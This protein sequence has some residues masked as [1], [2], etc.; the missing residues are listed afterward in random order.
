MSAAM[1]HA[2]PRAA[3]LG[4]A[5]GFEW[6]KLRTVRSTWWSVISA[7]L[8]LVAVGVIVGMSTAASGDNGYDVTRPAPHAA[9]EVYLIAQLPVVALAA[10]A[11]TSE[12]STG[13][14]RTTLQAVPV[15]GRML[16]A[17]AVVVAAATGGCGALLCLIGTVTIDLFAGGYTAYTASEL[18]TTTAASALYLGLLG[19]FTLGLGTLL[20]S[21]AGTIV[22]TVMLLLAVPQVMRLATIEWLADAS[23]YLPDTAGVV[24]MTQRDDPYG[25]GV[26]LAVLTG[27]AALALVAGYWRLATRDA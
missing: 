11:V 16:L 5:V 7:V 9:T 26:A 13:S 12:Y 14:I 10:L 6:L 4:E 18:A 8:L 27:W 1:S 21:A 17:K 15:R 19:L 3:G 22:A 20:R 24:L 25:G 2:R 23:Q